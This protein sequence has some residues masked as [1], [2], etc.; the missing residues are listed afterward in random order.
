MVQFSNIDGNKEEAEKE[1]MELNGGNSKRKSESH[2]EGGEMS[3]KKKKKN[4]SKANG[5]GHRRH[6][7]STKPARDPRD[8]ATDTPEETAV[9]VSRS[10]S[11]VI[12]F[13]GLS[14]PSMSTVHHRN[15]H[16]SFPIAIAMIDTISFAHTFAHLLEVANISFQAKAHEHVSMNLQ[17]KQLHE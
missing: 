3:K 17:N 4:K 6:S 12:D 9:E 14:R 2:G 5:H 7:V 8:E 13:D 11:P 15:F 10:P 1:N 16:S